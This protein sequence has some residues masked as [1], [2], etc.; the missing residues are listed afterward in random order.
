MLALLEGRQGEV[1]GMLRQRM[2]VASGEQRY[3]EAALLRDQIRA[4]EQTVEQQKSVRY[5]AIDQDVVGL[6]R[7]GGEVEVVMLFY[8]QGKLTA[9]RNYNLNW[10]LDEE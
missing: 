2:S 7:Q 1:V 9:R 3:E 10:Q 8:R 6:F 5:G 4:I